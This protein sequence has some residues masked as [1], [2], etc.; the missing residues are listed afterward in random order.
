MYTAWN[1]LERQYRKNVPEREEGS[2]GAERSGKFWPLHIPGLH[3]LSPMQASIRLLC[4]PLRAAKQQCAARTCEWWRIRSASSDTELSLCTC[5]P[6]AVDGQQR[7]VLYRCRLFWFEASWLRTSEFQILHTRYPFYTPAVTLDFSLPLL[8]WD[9]RALVT[10]NPGITLMNCESLQLNWGKL[11][12][13][14]DGRH[15]NWRKWNMACASLQKK[16]DNFRQIFLTW[17]LSQLN[18]TSLLLTWKRCISRG[19]C[20]RYIQEFPYSAQSWPHSPTVLTKVL[21]F[22]FSPVSIITSDLALLISAPQRLP[23]R[24]P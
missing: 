11:F 18:F 13:T 1:H 24:G 21:I 16:W 15:L 22:F 20:T 2:I 4:A 23:W 5:S 8:T 9:K 3:G 17:D 12:S 6:H 7:F 14:W 19:L 10:P